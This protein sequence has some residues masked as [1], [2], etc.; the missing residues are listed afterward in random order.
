MRKQLITFTLLLFI[1]ANFSYAYKISKEE[2]IYRKISNQNLTIKEINNLI[3]SYKDSLIIASNKNNTKKLAFYNLIISKLYYKLENYDNSIAFGKEALKNYKILKDT[4]FIMSSLVN[5]GAIYGQSDEQEIALDYFKQIEA[6]AK[7]SNDSMVLS[8]NYIDMGTASLDKDPTKSLYY[9]KKAEE[10]CSSQT[11]KESFLFYLTINRANTYF[12]MENYEKAKELYLKIYN[13]ID[14]THFFYNSL[15]TNIGLAYFKLNNIDS[16]LYYT[17]KALQIKQ[18]MHN[19]NN[20]ASTYSLLTKIYITKN[21]CDSAG[22]YMINYQD[23][24][25]S[26]IIKKKAE[27]TSKL[28]VIYETDKL[29]DNIK[30][31]KLK[32]E[33]S[34]IKIIFLSVV[35]TLITIVLM[36]FYVL[37]KKLRASYK[38]IVK[39]SIKNIKI[40]EENI[41]LKQEITP[42]ENKEKNKNIENKDEI[43]DK[44]IELF[45]KEKPYIDENFDIKELANKLDTNRTYVSKIINTKTGQSFVNFVNKYRVNEAK[46]IL[47]DEKYSNITLEAIGKM[48]GFKSS[49]T[50][51]RVFKQETGVTPSF[52][53]KNK[54]IN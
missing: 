50:F 35:L 23:Y 46:R 17:N 45:E 20:M 5:M 12:Y 10:Y 11:D 8:Y 25:D 24:V 13:V 37:Y 34:R 18:G 54:N 6:F 9:F 16:A 27:Y 40:E 42:S 21:N 41:K 43:Y 26:L 44:I 51:Y 38:Q 4:F 39:E 2:I 28:K 48:S 36:L 53:V 19:F 52:F 32:I 7:A 49:S 14:S 31:Q 33:R 15:C 1:F 30:Q 3:V 47:I 22:K 29:I